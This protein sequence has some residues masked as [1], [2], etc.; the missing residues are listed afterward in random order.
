[1][2]FHGGS[3]NVNDIHREDPDTLWKQEVYDEINA[4]KLTVKGLS[5]NR[6]GA[7]VSPSTWRKLAGDGLTLLKETKAQLSYIADASRGIWSIARAV[8]T[9]LP[10][11]DDIG[12]TLKFMSMAQ[13]H[14]A[15]I[16]NV[17]FNEQGRLV[18]ATERPA[19]DSQESRQAGT[20]KEHK[21]TNAWEFIPPAPYQGVVIVCA[22]DETVTLGMRCYAEVKGPGGIRT[23]FPVEFGSPS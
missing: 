22:H 10:L 2:V 11:L 1:M 19:S 8:E 5:T 7:R 6:S 14:E 23:K 17:E 3:I 21:G 20:T 4:L 9:I 13:L 18:F 15:G 12:T 16:A